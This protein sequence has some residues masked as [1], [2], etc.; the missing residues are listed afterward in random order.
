VK[1]SQKCI[2]KVVKIVWWDPSG[3]ER[4]PMKDALKGRP[5]LGK[6]TEYGVIDDITDGVVRLRQSEAR[7]GRGIPNDDDEGS[8][9]WTLEELVESIEILEPVKDDGTKV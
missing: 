8:Y 7:D 1:I 4:M 6:W 9:T 2:G 5:A 3:P